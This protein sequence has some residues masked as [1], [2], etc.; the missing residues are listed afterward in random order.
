VF[1]HRREVM[2]G[3]VCLCLLSVGLLFVR[4]VPAGEEKHAA[5]SLVEEAQLLAGKD[6]K[7][8]WISDEVIPAEP[9][10]KGQK[11]Y[12]TLQFE[13]EQGQAKGKANLGFE[14]RGVGVE[15]GEVGYTF[16]LGVG[17]E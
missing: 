16:E 5:R 2:R 6:G 4:S 12:I 15:G 13:P 14:I 3:I 11:T 17:V 1:G 8:R 7:N 10:K 9:E